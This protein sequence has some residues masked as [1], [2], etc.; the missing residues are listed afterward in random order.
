MFKLGLSSSSNV[1]T[2]ELF[3]EYHRSG[4]EAIEVNRCTAGYDGLDFDAL[5]DMAIRHFKEKIVTMHVSD[6]DLLDE[7]HWMPGKG[8]VDFGSIIRALRDVG[9]TGTWLYEVTFRLPPTSN[10]PLLLSDFAE[11]AEGLFTSAQ[12]NEY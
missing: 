9:Y 2:D 5:S 8:A 10:H 7:R 4:I 12:K 3:K 1:F 6:C 11:N